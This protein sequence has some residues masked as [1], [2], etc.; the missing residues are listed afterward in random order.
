[1]DDRW[2][3]SLGPDSTTEKCYLLVS[4]LIRVLSFTAAVLS[5]ST[6]LWIWVYKTE[7]FPRSEVDLLTF[8]LES[9]SKLQQWPKLIDFSCLDNHFI[10]WWT[11]YLWVCVCVCVLT[12]YM[13]IESWRQNYLIIKRQIK[14]RPIKIAFKKQ[15][16]CGGGKSFEAA[17]G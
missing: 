10:S 13:F 17:S 8:M 14:S 16:Q 6:L 4:L 7:T 5:V 3:K 12:L 9:S 15:N 11:T 1:M 2:M